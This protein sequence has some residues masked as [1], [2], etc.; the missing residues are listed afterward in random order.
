MRHRTVKTNTI[1]RSDK[2]RQR[3]STRRAAVPARQKRSVLPTR[4]APPVFVR[5]N[6]SLGGF[7][8]E[9]RKSRTRRRYD[10]ALGIP[11]AEVRLPSLP[12]V[13]FGWRLISSFLVAF[14]GMALY[15]LWTSPIYQVQDIQITGLQRLTPHEINTLLNISGEHIF[16]IDQD[17]LLTHLQSTFPELAAVTVDINL[18]AEVAVTVEERNPI[19]VWYQ[20]GRTLW[21]D[22]SGYSFPARES[23][24]LQITVNAAGAPALPIGADADPNQLL[25]PQFVEAILSVREVAPDGNSLV[26]STDHG[27]GW[28]EKKGW[29]VYLGTNLADIEMKLRVY[30]AI[31]KHLKQSGIQP[32]MVSVETVHSPYYRLEP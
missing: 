7:V 20:N 14:L 10:I 27:L 13:R 16:A 31:F 11:G 26:Y 23:E 9:R 4:G 24:P 19:L 17:L 30:D 25:T 15:V 3:H 29:T 5:G 21:V 1:A 6:V 8:A 32:A 12:Q 18:P 2:V 22:E 28:K